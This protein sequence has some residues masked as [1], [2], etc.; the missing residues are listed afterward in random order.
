[1][2]SLR[3]YLVFVLAIMFICL[4][5]SES[6]VLRT[7]QLPVTNIHN[8]NNVS[9]LVTF[10]YI[11]SNKPS[12]DY[13]CTF[14]INCG[15]VPFGIENS[16]EF[17]LYP[18]EIKRINITITNT[19]EPVKCLETVKCTPETGSETLPLET[20]RN[21]VVLP[22]FETLPNQLQVYLI[23]SNYWYMNK[24]A[25]LYLVDNYSEPTICKLYINGVTKN[26]AL[27][28][29]SVIKIN[30][31]N[32][33][34]YNIVHIECQNNG[35]KY[36]NTLAIKGI[37][38]HKLVD[39]SKYVSINIEK[40]SDGFNINVKNTYDQNIVCFVS[41]YDSNFKKKYIET[42]NVATPGKNSITTWMYKLKDLGISLSENVKI[43]VL[44]VCSA[45]Y[46][47]KLKTQKVLS[48]SFTKNNAELINLRQEFFGNMVKIINLYS[49][50]EKY[51]KKLDQWDCGDHKTILSS[52]KSEIGKIF[53]QYQDDKNSVDAMENLISQQNKL[54]SELQKLYENWNEEVIKIANEY[55]IKR[56]QFLKNYYYVKNIYN[57]MIKS[58]CIS[59][60]LYKNQIDQLDNDYKY[61][62]SV[63][64]VSCVLLKKLPTMINDVK[65]VNQSLQ[66]KFK[67]CKKIIKN[68]KYKKELLKKIKALYNEMYTLKN[69]LYF[70]YKG[71]L[72]Y[73]IV[74]MFIINN[75]SKLMV[76]CYNLE[77]SLNSMSYEEA[78]EQYETIKTIFEHEYVFLRSILETLIKGKLLKFGQ[79]T[80]VFNKNK[81]FLKTYDEVYKI[82]NKYYN[83]LMDHIN[84]NNDMVKYSKTIKKDIII[85][86]KNLNKLDK[87]LVHIEIYVNDTFDE[88]VP[89]AKVFIDGKFVGYTNGNGFLVVKVIKGPQTIEVEA[90]SYKKQ[91]KTVDVTL[92][93]QLIVVMLK[94]IS[95][96]EKYS[97]IVEHYID[98]KVI[99]GEICS[100]LKHP[101]CL[102]N[103]MVHPGF[104]Q[105]H[106][107]SDEIKNIISKIPKLYITSCKVDNNCKSLLIY[108]MNVVHNIIHYN[109]KCLAKNSGK[110]KLREGCMA[111]WGSDYAILSYHTGVCA[112]FARITVSLLRA[113]GIPARYVIIAAR[114]NNHWKK[115]YGANFY[116]AFTQVYING[117][118]VFYDTLWNYIGKPV[119]PLSCISTVETPYT[120]IEDGKRQ[121][122]YISL[123]KQM[124]E[125]YPICPGI[126]GTKI[127]S[128]SH[129]PKAP[130]AAPFEQTTDFDNYS[131]LIFLQNKTVVC[132]VNNTIFSLSGLNFN[133][134]INVDHVYKGLTRSLI[135]GTLNNTTIAAYVAPGAKVNILICGLNNSTVVS[136]GFVAINRSCVLYT[137]GL[138]GLFKIEIAYPPF[139]YSDNALVRRSAMLYGYLVIN[140]STLAK[141]TDMPVSLSQIA[142]LGSVNQELATLYIIKKH[143]CPSGISILNNLNI[144]N[145][146]DILLNK[147]NTLVLVNTTD[148]MDVEHNLLNLCQKPVKFRIDTNPNHLYPDVSNDVVR[149][150]LL[151]IN[152]MNMFV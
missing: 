147:P 124:S 144:D 14:T 125:Y 37:L 82:V 1:M 77:N 62:S 87:F 13:K 122:V 74:Q 95:T 112:D 19:T 149:I 142:V 28:P 34:D 25:V 45:P 44:V 148:T 136:P 43:G 96:T 75:I 110:V 76:A 59:E 137:S 91:I 10:I 133:N 81:E 71:N 69:K 4:G 24:P 103:S 57:K 70:S 66:L 78:E 46:T 120:T 98:S 6:V 102:S 61:V 27:T 52:L 114:T 92:D 150:C 101:Q 36:F 42:K 23:T 88:A 119:Y 111:W 9:R 127:P 117:H 65:K 108:L 129:I 72:T 3:S 35:N 83:D 151:G 12:I 64:T 100:T 73:I 17:D 115:Y 67:V 53:L 80:K 20:E 85:C 33:L 40:T 48:Y 131:C 39:L 97:P 56:K 54:I 30:V 104:I 140:N 7:F 16:T 94:P 51:G 139:F 86:I 38:F 21:F 109:N 26:I 11:P 121:T 18:N 93:N 22:F 106:P 105:L 49:K 58:K 84:S 32:P 8:Y 2:K 135:F 41:V 90:P 123:L 146:N 116:H 118:W 113:L 31:E 99:F 79:Y 134:W 128:S 60:S 55:S 63:L 141:I 126:R 107:N 47:T 5:Y 132:Q 138:P 68:P 89:L 29:G 50:A 143:T 152:Y 15:K 130:L 145:I